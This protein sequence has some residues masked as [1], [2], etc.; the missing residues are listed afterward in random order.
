MFGKLLLIFILGIQLAILL[1]LYTN[2]PKSF[3][4][5]M[6]KLDPTD[7]GGDDK[8]GDDNNNEQP[9]EGSG[10][11]ERHAKIINKL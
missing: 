7:D 11:L 2:N 8:G 9:E 1:V 3:A 6:D 10:L 4:E 5:A